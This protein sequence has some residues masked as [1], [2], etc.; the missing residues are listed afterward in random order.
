MQEDR[1]NR[2]IDLAHVL[3]QEP[4]FFMI[5]ACIFNKVVK[6]VYRNGSTVA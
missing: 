1:V 4:D 6:D 2:I 3:G 5:T